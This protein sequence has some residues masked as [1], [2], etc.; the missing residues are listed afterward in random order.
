MFGPFAP[1]NCNATLQVQRWPLDGHAP[2]CLAAIGVDVVLLQAEPAEATHTEVARGV[3]SG[4]S[5]YEFRDYRLD[6]RR[7]VL[8]WRGEVLRTTP[9]VFATLLYMVE[10]AG[11]LLSKDEMLAALWPG[12]VVDEDNLSQAISAVRKLLAAGGASGLVR[13]VSGQGYC[14]TG[15]VGIEPVAE[16]RAPNKP[17]TEGVEGADWPTSSPA[18]ASQLDPAAPLGAASR[19]HRPSGRLIG[20]G[21]A[22][23]LVLLAGVVGLARLATRSGP[24]STDHTGVVLA[25]PQNFTDEHDLSPV[26]TQILRADLDQSPLLRLASD[27]K[28]QE[29]LALMELPSSAPLTEQTARAV[30]SRNNGGAVIAP[31]ITRLRERYVLT[32]SAYDCV[33]GATLF[34]EKAETDS[35]EAVAG[36]I[37]GLA[38]RLRGRLGEVQSSIARFDTP[39]E[40]ARTRSFAA[41]RA[42]SEGE[43]LAHQGRLLEAVPFYQH[44][45]ELDPDFASAYLGQALAFYELHQSARDEIAISQAF[46]RIAFV[47]ERSALL[48][49]NHYSMVVT[50]DLDAARDSME[51]M[52]E[53]YPRDEAAWLTLSD[54][55]FR[56]A[57]F[58]AA[59]AAG[60]HALQLDPKRSAVY[61]VLA[62]AL[63]HVGQTARA[64]ALDE[65]SLK[66]VPETGQMRQQRIAW[67]YLR[68]DVADAERLVASARGT[69]LEREALLESY[70][71]VFAA[72]RLREA[73]ALMAQAE[74]LG[75][76]KGLRPEDGERA[77]N[78]LDVEAL[79]LATAALSKITPDAWS[80]EDDYY[81]ARLKPLAEAQADLKRDMA[82]WPQDTLLNGKYALEARAAMLMRQGHPLE[83]AH[84]LDGVGRLMF[85]DLDAPFLQASAFLAAGD[86]ADAVR[87]FRAVLAQTGSGWDTQYA[88]AHLGLARALRQQGDARGSHREYAI[89][90]QDWKSADADL[91]PLRQARAEAATLPAAVQQRPL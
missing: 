77:F 69:P 84:V 19:P 74:A 48:I 39:L 52:T 91:A 40:P 33:G 85:R 80:G 47:S 62:R 90:L 35:K 72:G 22:G 24:L 88:L 63:N 23:L 8:T 89:F 79:P 34:D 20:V 17:Q 15:E 4:A 31:V 73:D 51:L 67:R 49:R 54:T 37:D 28:V 57:E 12:R 9:R 50:R 56:L 38:G 6:P 81:A 5:I 27:M 18:S 11:R 32:L 76:R 82:R 45:V 87:G 43:Q 13:T 2:A 1:I 75:R 65:A 10:N 53:L 16:P 59:V 3:A 26:V 42:Y 86:T 68:G 55:C 71:F 70:N 21:L 46:K 29:T 78:Y 14:F 41:L 25:D 58:P 36:L 64:E 61:T 83:A 66:L 60:E 30:C 44:A 7:H